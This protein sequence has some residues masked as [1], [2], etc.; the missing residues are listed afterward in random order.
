MNICPVCRQEYMEPPALSRRDNKTRICSI[1]ATKEALEDAGIDYER[2]IGRA[3]IETV[4]SHTR[5][6]SPQERTRAAVMRTGNKWA[7]E[8]FKDTH[9]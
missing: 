5:G 9:N 2:G 3:V 4:R 6:I 8:N 1:C 7:M